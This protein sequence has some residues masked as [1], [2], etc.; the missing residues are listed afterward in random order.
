MN[1]ELQYKNL[2]T[3]KDFDLA[4]I[5]YASKQVLDSSYWERQTCFFVFEDEEVCKKVIT[6]YFKDKLIL[7]PKSLVDAQKTI[8]SILLYR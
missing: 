4:S 1:E 6:D 5:L 2:Y 3:T 8:K 7:S